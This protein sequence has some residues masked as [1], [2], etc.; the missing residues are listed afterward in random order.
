M[1]HV[2]LATVN[3]NAVQVTMKVTLNRNIA[4]G[5]MLMYQKQEKCKFTSFLN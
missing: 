5:G 3:K 1:F 2:L 4:L